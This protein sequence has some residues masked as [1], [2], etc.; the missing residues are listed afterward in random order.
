MSKIVAI[1]VTYN[2]VDML[3]ECVN[4]ILAQSYPL[5]KILI[6]NNA[7]TDS[8]GKLIEKMEIDHP[9][10]VHGIELKKNLGGAGGFTYGL[11][12]ASLYDADFIWM[13]D[14]DVEPRRDCLEHLLA[15]FEKRE[16]AD[17]V[18]PLVYGI[19]R[20]KIQG[21]QHK[22]LDRYLMDSEAPVNGEASLIKLD[23]NAF[24]GPLIRA[25]S[26]SR[27]GLP[28]S[29]YFIWADDLEYTFRIGNAGKL[30]LSKDAVIDHKDQQG[31]PVAWKA[32]YG[33]RNYM[34]FIRLHR[35]QSSCYALSV[36]LLLFRSARATISITLKGDD[37]NRGKAYLAPL[38]ALDGLLGN[39]NRNVR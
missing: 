7:S 2:R 12:A 29:Q 9:D 18:C 3:E 22:V 39:W 38:G 17:M 31:K 11:L 10:L 13:M 36:G 20:Q 19:R 27:Y 32:Y 16:D 37:K 30:Y 34:D 23:A 6:V 1:V 14:D 35:E 21:H 25:A 4:A 26:L 8:T 5:Y 15:G 28:I 24:V 33:F